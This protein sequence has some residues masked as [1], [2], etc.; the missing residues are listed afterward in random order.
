MAK[1]NPNEILDVVHAFAKNS[2]GKPLRKK[3]KRKTFDVLQGVAELN[4]DGDIIKRHQNGGWIIS[5]PEAKLSED[6]EQIVAKATRGRKKAV[7]DES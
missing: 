6:S 4:S 5:A 2:D 7:T 1:T 3:M